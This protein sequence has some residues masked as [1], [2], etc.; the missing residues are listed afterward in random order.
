MTSLERALPGPGGGQ[1]ISLAAAEAAGPAQLA[2]APWTVRILAENILRAAHRAPAAGRA[3]RIAEALHV[4][5]LLT[6]AATGDASAD[7]EF[8][9]ARLLLQDHSGVPVLADIATLRSTLA[10]QGIDP[11][12]AAPRLPVDLVVDH[13]VEAHHS[14]GPDA[15]ALNMRREYELNSERYCLLRWAQGAVDGLRV[16]PPGKGIVHQM[17]LEHLA[18]V[19]TR[20]ADGLLIPDTVLGTDSH[21]PM[22]NA[23]GVLGFGIGGIDASA[24][25]LG[26]PLPLRGPRVVGVRLTG[27]PSPGVSATDVALTLTELLRQVGV[28]ETMVEF[29][30]PGIRALS[31]ADRATLANMAP[32]YGCTT[33]YFPVDEQVLGYLRL[34]GRPAEQVALVETY[35]RAQGLFLDHRGE[36]TERLYWRTVELNLAEVEPS[37]AGP[38]RP[39]DRLPLR[40]TARSLREV[41]GDRPAASAG[42][43][44]VD[45]AVGIAAITSC[46][47][48]STPVSM[49]TAGLLAR[50]A[51]AAGLTVPPWVK[52]TLAPGS[53]TV[54]RYLR[55]A[56]VLEP[57]AALGFSVVGYGC[58][59][60]IGNSGPLHPE[61]AELIEHK[62]LKAVAVLSGNRNFEGRIHRDVAAAYLMAPA[63]VI[64][65]GLAGHIG[66]DITSD[67][68]GRGPD[69]EPVRLADLWP[70]PVQITAALRSVDAGHYAADK[71]EL[72]TGDDT[73][74]GLDAPSGPLFAWQEGSQYLL[75]SPLV[76]QPDRDGL[77]DLRDARVLVFAE[78]ST[79]TDHIS[80]A[81]QIPTDTPAGRYLEGRG[82]RLAD[83]NSYGCR[84][85]NHHVMVR[86]TFAGAG[87][88][89]RLVA[90]RRGGFTRLLPDGEESDVHG[91][92]VAYAEERTPVIVLAGHNYGMGSS[93][94]WAA[95]GTR[96]LGV[97]A[98]LAQSFER[99]HRSNLVA[100]GVVPLEF[101]PGQGP[102]E[103]GLTGHE[104]YDVRLSG[105]TPRSLVEVTARSESREVL[106]RWTMRA[107]VESRRELDYIQAGGLLGHVTRRFTQTA[108]QS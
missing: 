81:G 93:R 57:L 49:L 103:L 97:R 34:T 68:L 80:P 45:G 22:V 11:R 105:L 50:N 18:H 28:V 38:R 54:T 17:H 84:R 31:V 90:G 72:F 63:L 87:L 67:P 14:S 23:I 106:A 12:L 39:Q 83:F 47:N 95:K 33:A 35:T 4:T 56:G 91:V 6:R 96:L 21:T 36:E 9:P 94:D 46:T 79:T 25:M 7:I 108:E 48:T 20:D 26:L 82:I 101:L 61:L 42:T 77:E 60:C 5:E 1:Y 86:G 66:L 37:V 70:T 85:G 24:A 107:R 62:D 52:A 19:V 102:D 55:A 92:A 13:S 32:E 29:T 75:R 2:R 98:V 76:G 43:G 10:E 73:W 53:R 64:A 41:L 78:D 74:N 15:L 99:I 58:T 88:R 104:L 65:F 16:V 27:A 71:A 8:Q 44:P 69:G 30:G 100:A 40:E 89:N 59:T 51:V 3:Q